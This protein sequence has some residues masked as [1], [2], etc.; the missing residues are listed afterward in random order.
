MYTVKKV[1]NIYTSPCHTTSVGYYCTCLSNVL[2]FCY[3]SD[4]RDSLSCVPAAAQRNQI[5]K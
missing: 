3:L 4:P 1:G 2:L 5:I